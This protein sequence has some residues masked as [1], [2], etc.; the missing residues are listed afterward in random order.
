M[1][2]IQR[3]TY[4]QSGIPLLQDANLQVFA[5]QRVG[6]VGT[7]G[8]GKSTLFRLIRGEIKPDNGEI[9]LQSGKTI[10]FVEQ[11]IINSSQPAL[12]FVLDGDVEL[13]QLEKIL[14][15]AEHDI[16]WFEA[17]QRY[18]TTN[19]YVARARAAQLLNGLGFSNN[20]LERPV[21]QFSGGWRMRLNLARALMHRADLLLLDEPTNH[22]DLEA[23][24]WLEQYLACYPGSLIVVSHDREFLNA[25]INRIA[26]IHNQQIDSYTGN[27]DDFEHIRAERHL[28]QTQA[29]QQQ[30]KKIAHMEDFVRRF[31]AKATK[32]K[33]AQSRLKA[34]ERLTRIVPVQTEDGYFQL[35]IEAPQYSPDV[36]LRVK[37]MSFGYNENPLFQH[38]HLTLQAGARI[39]LLGPNGAGKSTLI[40]LLMNEIKPTSG[41]VEM[42]PDIRIGYFAQHQ[43]EN[44]DAAATPLQH[45]I[46]L[47]P[48]QT[49]LELRNFLGQFGLGGNSEDR[50]VVS[51]SGGEKSRLA[52][53]LLAWQ[54][55]HILLLD[56][57][58][59]HLDLDMRDALTL[60]LEAYTGAVVL[61]SHDRS[62]VRS[63]ADELWLVAD[64]E[65]RL[66]DGD[67]EDYKNWIEKGRS[68]E[69][70]QSQSKSQK[71][72]PKVVSGQNK[73]ALLSKQAKLE[74][75]L[76]I[77][78]TE[79]AAVS[80]QLSDPK[81]YT[82][83]TR[84][85]VN[86]LTDVH[87]D[88][89]RKIAELEENWLELEAVIGE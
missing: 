83:C 61:V 51:F 85:E 63:V 59:N 52:L 44:L 72:K 26:H 1:L 21:N 30:Q 41:S 4:L 71:L 65:A 40:K 49:E 47:A 36:L 60:A 18:E 24:L 12:E 16:A 43:L 68:G 56:E 48:K 87:K 50:P 67:L 78:Q 54:K 79:L 22:L 58:T 86:R 80:R 88:L 20:I 8:C 2:N 82:H 27:Y 45:M 70:S 10:T 6:L 77:A 73:R 13:R 74:A 55:P 33:Q 38:V 64:G 81:T 32:A 9:N 31:R 76:T 39:A 34:L 5:N 29:F 35:R 7:N 84:D 11:E 89:E 15:R 23:I 69:S 75:A 37:E 25:C 28:Q 42:A 46:R 19:G 66:F 57:P 53:A 3:L 14:A 17:Q 62:L